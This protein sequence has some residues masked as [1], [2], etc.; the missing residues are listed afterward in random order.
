MTL[1][2]ATE[3]VEAKM[4]VQALR[5]TNGNILKAAASLGISRQKLYYFIEQHGILLDRF[6]P[7][8]ATKDS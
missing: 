2:E 7:V 3:E 4:V 6:R 8:K 1:K 5:Q